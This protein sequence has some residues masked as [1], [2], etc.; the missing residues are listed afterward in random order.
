[1]DFDMNNI[2]GLIRKMPIFFLVL[3]RMA[4]I[5]F[6]AP[7][8]SN[9]AFPISIKASFAFF[10]TLIVFHSVSFVPEDLP[11][12]MLSFGLMTLKELAVGAIIGFAGAVLF[13]LFSLAGTVVGRQ[14]GLEMA[15]TLS[16]GLGTG[17]SLIGFIYYLIATMIFLSINGHHWL[18]RTLAY[19]Y[20]A[21][22]L[23]GFRFTPKLTDKFTDLFV[24][25]YAQGVKMGGPF[26]IVGFLTLILVGIVLKVTQQTN[27]FVLELPMKALVGFAL[28]IVA[29]PYI[30]FLMT[31]I[32]EKW[33]SELITILRFMR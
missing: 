8:F 13:M 29:V 22:P 19:S 4:G 18:I 16:P 31:S 26:I 20:R 23:A 21:V 6:A 17:G 33:Q 3:S 15:S 28:L 12:T 14:I 32:L 1:M 30:V 10:L 24:T 25:Y 5:F 11:D 7:V 2:N 27:L 9:K